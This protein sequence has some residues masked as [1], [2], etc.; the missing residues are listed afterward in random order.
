MSEGWSKDRIL[1]ERLAPLNELEGSSQLMLDAVIP[2]QERE[3][4]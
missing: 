1:D 3:I 2:G 4:Y